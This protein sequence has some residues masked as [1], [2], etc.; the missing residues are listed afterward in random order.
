MAKK[1]VI[2]VA[3]Y[4]KTIYDGIEHQVLDV[5]DY[6]PPKV[7][8]HGADTIVTTW[9]GSATEGDKVITHGLGYQPFVL[10]YIEDSPG[11]GKRYLV[12]ASLPGILV[13]FYYSVD[14]SEIIIVANGIG[15][16][17]GTYNLYYY[18]FLDELIT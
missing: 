14:T 5:P 17:A 3:K 7:A 6:P 8:A 13:P 12:N 9:N 11:S 15:N 1:V 16:F 10:V 2:K 4:G 18:V